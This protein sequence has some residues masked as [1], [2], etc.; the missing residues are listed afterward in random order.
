MVWL[1]A[2]QNLLSLPYPME[3]CGSRFLRCSYQFSLWVHSSARLF[4]YFGLWFLQFHVEKHNVLCI[5]ESVFVST[6]SSLFLPWQNHSSPEDQLG[7]SHFS[8][9]PLPL[10]LAGCFFKESVRTLKCVPS[11]VPTLG[12]GVRTEAKAALLELCLSSKKGVHTGSFHLQWFPH[13][14]NDLRYIL[15]GRSRVR[16]RLLSLRSD[17]HWL[18]SHFLYIISYSIATNVSF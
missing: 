12:G 5:H 18:A 7:P 10:F 8:P 14:P 11:S 15:W 16:A 13:T 9:K 4:I 3:T 17:Q 6:W 1:N 2:G